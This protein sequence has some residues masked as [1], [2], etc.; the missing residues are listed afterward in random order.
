MTK[1]EIITYVRVRAHNPALIL[2]IIEQESSFNEKAT[3]NDHNGGSFGLMQL[4]IPTARDMGILTMIP[5][6]YRTA[7]GDRLA[8]SKA[9]LDPQINMQIGMKYIDWI[10]SYLR[11]KNLYTLERNIA[12]YNVGVGNVVK[13]VSDRA[14]S[15]SVLLRYKRWQAQLAETQGP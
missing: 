12:A 5:S 9:L 3:A 14:Y 6:V 15:D 11:R 4:N 13:G 2:A 8:I 10:A 7:E 1:D